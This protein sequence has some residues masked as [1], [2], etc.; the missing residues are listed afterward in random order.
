MS[1]YLS[2]VLLLHQDQV[3][4]HPYTNGIPPNRSDLGDHVADVHGDRMGDPMEEVNHDR[5]TVELLLGRAGVR[6]E[7]D[8]GGGD[9]LRIVQ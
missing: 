6:R 8:I 1:F 9:A 7:A 5:E 4:Y 3:C 2:L